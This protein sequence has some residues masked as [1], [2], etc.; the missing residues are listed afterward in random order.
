MARSGYG[1]LGPFATNWV[2][3]VCVYLGGK[4]MRRAAVLALLIS[5]LFVYSAPSVPAQDAEPAPLMS[6][7]IELLQPIAEPGVIGARFKGDHMYVTSVTGLTVYDVSNAAAP[8]EVGRLPLPHFEN[9]DVDLGGNILLISND[10]AESTG[11]LH[12]IN[13]EEPAAPALLTSFQM[14]GNPAEGGPGHT[15]S[16]ILKCKFAWVTD[17]GEMKVIDLRDPAAPVD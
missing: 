17:G 13:I 1:R 15:A 12:V 4:S 11:I 16:C 9:E 8:A 3:P 14:G 6:S 5:S 10:A 7:N 2:K